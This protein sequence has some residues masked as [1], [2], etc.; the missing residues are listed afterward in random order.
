VSFV[1]N[2]SQCLHGRLGHRFQR[3]GAALVLQE[4]AN[5]D[6]S[7]LAATRS[8][9]LNDPTVPND[10]PSFAPLTP[11]NGGGETGSEL[12]TLEAFLTTSVFSYCPQVLLAD[13]RAA[14]CVLPSTSTIP[15]ASISFHPGTAGESR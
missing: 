12:F 15:T 8:A 11:Q 5:L 10:T 13:A 4:G 14:Q 1:L 9:F 6:P 3:V 2:S 7:G